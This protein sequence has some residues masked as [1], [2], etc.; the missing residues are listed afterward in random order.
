MGNDDWKFEKQFR[1]LIKCQPTKALGFMKNPF[2][3][4]YVLH[5]ILYPL[6]STL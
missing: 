4:M 6:I 1:K 2:T 5:A 3:K